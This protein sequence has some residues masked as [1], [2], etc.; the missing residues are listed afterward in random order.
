ML[1]DDE[2]ENDLT[3]HRQLEMTDANKPPVSDEAVQKK[4]GK[5]WAEWFDLLDAADAASLTHGEIV[6]LLARDHEI[7]PWWQ[8]SVTVGYERARGLREKHQGSGGYQVGASKTAGVPVERLYAAWADEALRAEWLPDTRF[9]VRK[10]T[11]S[12]SMRITWGDE[13]SVDVYFYAKGGEKS[14]VSVDHRKLPDPDAV[15]RMRAFWRERFGVL[16]A[17]LE[18]GD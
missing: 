1:A 16:K 3:I 2:G 13:T 11:P 18:Q 15:E 4:T 5:S 7:D 10:A 9:T 17:L 14:Q 6:K 12:K 8:Q